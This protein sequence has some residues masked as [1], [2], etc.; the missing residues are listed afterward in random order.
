MSFPDSIYHSSGR[1]PILY[2]HFLDA[3][4][5]YLDTAL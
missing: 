1:S 3:L 5:V 4:V 2:L